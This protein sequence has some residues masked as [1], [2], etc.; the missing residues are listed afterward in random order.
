MRIHSGNEFCIAASSACPLD[1][2]AVGTSPL[3]AL[4]DAGRADS[5]EMVNAYFRVE[6]F[7]WKQIY[8][9]RGVKEFIHQ[10]RLH[11]AL[12]MAERLGLPAHACALDVGCGAGLAAVGLAQ[13]GFRV[14]AVDAIQVMLDATHV[15]AHE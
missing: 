1:S 12:T 11:A 5:Q 15:R 13:Q 9:R 6:A 8:E 14:V 4:D 10:Q 7:Y 2:K 3:H